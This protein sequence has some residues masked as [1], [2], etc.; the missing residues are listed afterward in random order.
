MIGRIFG[1]ALCHIAA[2]VVLG[3]IIFVDDGK[4]FDWPVWTWCLAGVTVLTVVAS[5]VLL[6][7]GCSLTM[8]AAAP[9]VGAVAMFMTAAV[10]DWRAI[11]SKAP[12]LA[13]LTGVLLPVLCNIYFLPSWVAAL[14]PRVRIARVAL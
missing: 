3:F 10:F 5:R 11:S 14:L 6:Y 1:S 4:Y 13:A 12:P 8:R 2:G 7:A 9:F